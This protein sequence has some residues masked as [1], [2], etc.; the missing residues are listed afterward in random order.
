MVISVKHKV[1]HNLVGLL[2]YLLR[3]H[4]WNFG[5]RMSCN[6]YHLWHV[7][8]NHK[9]AIKTRFV[10]TK[11]MHMPHILNKIMCILHIYFNVPLFKMIAAGKIKRWTWNIRWLTVCPLFILLVFHWSIICS[12]YT[13]F[14]KN[15]PAVH[16]Y[17]KKI[18]FMRN[19]FLNQSSPVRVL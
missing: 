16:L 5:K 17:I 11:N 8:M 4:I 9:W 12:I 13:A 14:C 3:K 2:N 7:H 18:F 1:L 10:H 19:E 6:K 15:S